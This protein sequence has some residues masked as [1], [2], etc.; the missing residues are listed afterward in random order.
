M[1][2]HVHNHIRIEFSTGKS[3][4][5]VVDGFDAATL[6]V[7]SQGRTHVYDHQDGALDQRHQVSR[8]VVNQSPRL[9]IKQ[10][11]WIVVT[12]TTH[13]LIEAQVTHN[14]DGMLELAAHGHVIY[15]DLDQLPPEITSIDTL[16]H[17]TPCEAGDVFTGIYQHLLRAIPRHKRTTGAL[18]MVGD[19]TRAFTGPPQAPGYVAPVRLLTVRPMNGVKK[20]APEVTPPKMKQTLFTLANDQITPFLEKWARSSREDESPY[21]YYVND[22]KFASVAW[23]DM[24]NGIVDIRL[25]TGDAVCEDALMIDVHT[26]FTIPH[27][28]FTYTCAPS[29]PDPPRIKDLKTITWLKALGFTLGVEI[30]PFMVSSDVFTVGKLLTKTVPVKLVTK[31][32]AAIFKYP[33]ETVLRRLDVLPVVECTEQTYP[34]KPINL[35]SSPQTQ[36]NSLRQ[37]SKEVKR[38]GRQAEP[39]ALVVNMMTQLIDN[40]HTTPFYRITHRMQ[41]TLRRRARPSYEP[42]ESPETKIP[43]VKLVHSPRLDPIL[44]ATVPL[45]VMYNF[46]EYILSMP[47]LV[48]YKRL[49]GGEEAEVD[50]FALTCAHNNTALKAIGERALKSVTLN[51]LKSC[52]QDTFAIF[53]SD[54]NDFAAFVVNECIRNGSI[55]FKTHR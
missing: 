7:V 12:F 39:T 41:V 23:V 24:L 54:P 40:A 28:V 51:E 19:M 37:L 4:T 3:L 10:G 55:Q 1:Y 32:I 36:L 43:P 27:P 33:E 35:N 34:I 46:V 42:S 47:S 29:C 52:V 26:G 18:R 6:T 22:A 13:P 31:A 20:R 44:T 50:A 11:D 48:K 15:I 53:E 49:F 25:R 2:L 16:A 45:Y 17:T 9:D 38:Q 8:I 30:D 5:G 14:D 21:W